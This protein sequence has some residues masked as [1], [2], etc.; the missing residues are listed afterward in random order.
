MLQ[1]GHDEYL[2]GAGDVVAIFSMGVF[3]AKR[4]S[5]KRTRPQLNRSTT[6]TS[7]GIKWYVSGPNRVSKNSGM[8]RV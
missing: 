4:K 7:G 1:H 8:F 2:F 5:H 3:V 6:N